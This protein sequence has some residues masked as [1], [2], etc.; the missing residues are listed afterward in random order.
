MKNILL[1][2][3][4]GIGKTTLV[5]KV[6][7]GMS[8]LSI[9]GFYTAEIREHGKRVGFRIQTFDGHSGILSHQNYHSGPRVGKYVVDIP[10]FEHIGV[11]ALEKAL[12]EARIIL[13]DEIGKMELFSQRFKDILIRCLDSPKPVLATVLLRP[14]L[15]TD[16]LKQRSDVKLLEVTLENRD[17]LAEKLIKEVVK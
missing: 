16:Q 13:I 17:A 6:A 1:E 4:P 12:A 2:G 9:G 8:N 14:H 11:T 3:E 10:A 7:G 5:R 15:F